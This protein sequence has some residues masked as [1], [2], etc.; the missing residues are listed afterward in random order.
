M[1]R[2]CDLSVSYD[3]VEVLRGV[4]MEVKAKE[5][6]AL[7][8]A[9]GSGKSTILKAVS[10]LIKKT[11]GSISF[12]EGEISHLEA[13]KRVDLGIVQ[14]PEGRRVFP[15]MSVL[16]NLLVGAYN[17]KARK[18]T[19]EN[20]DFVFQ[21]FPRLFERKH[22]VGNTLSGGEQQMLAIGRALLEEPK[23]LMLDE[24]SLGLAPVI[25]D[26]VYQTLGTIY[27]RGVSI[28]LVEENIY[29]AF[30]VATRG[31]VLENGNIVLSGSRTDL[32]STPFV[33]ES[34]MGIK[35]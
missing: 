3:V 22:Q 21:L 35:K 1:L 17:K 7:V 29:R 27:E 6:V 10:G 19:K 14:V 5:C 34:Y 4:S 26:E 31:Y 15:E 20:L 12:E 25:V 30:S 8:G 24:P 32:L 23:L 33:K 11:K 2:I 18:K 28:L 13:Y 16:D 9:N